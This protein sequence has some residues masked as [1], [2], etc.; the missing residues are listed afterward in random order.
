MPGAGVVPDGEQSYP[1]P[2]LIDRIAAAV[3]SDQ[4]LPPDREG[5]AALSASL[6][7]AATEKAT[8]V[9]AA[10]DLVDAV[11]NKTWRFGD[12]ALRVRAIGLKLAGANPT[13]ELTIYSG[14]P[15]G[16]DAILSEPV[17]L[18]GRWRSK[19][20]AYAFVANKGR[21][22]DS[23]TFMLERRFLGEGAMARRDAARRGGPARSS[24]QKHRWVRSRAARRSGELT[25]MS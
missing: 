21:W 5:E 24:I 23:R 14:E 9:G 1:L 10:S 16:A 8:P 17:G 6:L 11:S 18:D 4:P 7:K 15:G 13:V 2:A 22:L 12:N 19:L 20:T 3:K 25:P